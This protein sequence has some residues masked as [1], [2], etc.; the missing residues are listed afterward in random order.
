MEINYDE[1]ELLEEG[2]E[3]EPA[4]EEN[5]GIPAEDDE[6]EEEEVE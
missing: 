5:F 6:L 3:E 1:I 4:K 2:I